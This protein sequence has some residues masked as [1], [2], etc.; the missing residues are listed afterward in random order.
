MGIK[1]IA[2]ADFLRKL[3]E[4][5]VDVTFTILPTNFLRALFSY[6]PAALLLTP[7]VA[8]AKL[9]L[10]VDYSPHHPHWLRDRAWRLGTY[11]KL[12]FHETW[13]DAIAGVWVLWKL[14]DIDLSRL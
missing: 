8:I 5:W 1:P 4:R 3:L 6:V 14:P 11:L 12:A 9:L 2:V 13:R 10:R 7:A